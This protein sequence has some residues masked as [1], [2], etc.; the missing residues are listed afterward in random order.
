MS[1]ADAPTLD[2]HWRPFGSA[3]FGFSFSLTQPNSTNS[4]RSLL[5]TGKAPR[6]R[7]SGGG[8]CARIGQIARLCSPK[9]CFAALLLLPN[10]RGSKVWAAA[11][12]AK[13]PA[14]HSQGPTVVQL[15]GGRAA[16]EHLIEF[17]PPPLAYCF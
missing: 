3:D 7:L 11:N 5:S 6:R 9:V 16:G 14:G 1:N 15:T 2:L 17:E 13:S 8:N 4:T 10:Q 12:L